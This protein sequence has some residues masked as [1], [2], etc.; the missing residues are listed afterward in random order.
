MAGDHSEMLQILVVVGFDAADT[1]GVCVMLQILMEG[2]NAHVHTPQTPHPNCHPH[3][4]DSNHPIA[5]S[6]PSPTWGSAR[7]GSPWL[8]LWGSEKKLGLKLSLRK[9]SSADRGELGFSRR[10]SPCQVHL[11]SARGAVT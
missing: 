7:V 10:C 8:G 9:S 1:G 5:P 3:L 2:S 4:G 6:I 11:L